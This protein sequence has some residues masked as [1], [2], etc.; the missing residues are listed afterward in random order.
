MIVYG[1]RA[2]V[3]ALWSALAVLAVA[4]VALAEFIKVEERTVGRWT[5]T[6]VVQTDTDEA[7]CLVTTL[8]DLGEHLNI[9]IER[10]KH[11]WSL[12]FAGRGVQLRRGD[13]GDFEVTYAIDDNEPR[14]AAAI[15]TETGRVFVQL[16]TDAALMEPVR[17]GSRIAFQ[18]ADGTHTF[19]LDGSSRALNALRD[20]ANRHLGFVDATSST[21]P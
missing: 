1:M 16:G 14:R 13:A 12:A 18:T 10:P 7:L 6:A 8:N 19:S 5:L 9:I 3:A 11:L 21:D 4:P 15:P 17:R 2:L 20:C